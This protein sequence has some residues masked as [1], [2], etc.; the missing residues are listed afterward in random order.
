MPRSYSK[1][2]NTAQKG[3]ANKVKAKRRANYTINNS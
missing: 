3:S 2:Y 1:N